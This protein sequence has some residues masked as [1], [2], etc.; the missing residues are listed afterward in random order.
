LPNTSAT[1]APAPVA[2][3]C[4]S[5]DIGAM[6]P[7]PP[8]RLV[9][10]G[11]VG[12]DGVPM[13][14]RFSVR[15]APEASAVEA[16]LEAA[17]DFAAHEVSLHV[18][19]AVDGGAGEAGAV[20]I[21]AVGGSPATAA[22]TTDLVTLGALRCAH[23]AF[24]LDLR[25]SG[26]DVPVHFV[27]YGAWSREG[28]YVLSV[29]GD[30]FHAAA[31]DAFADEAAKTLLLKDPAPPAP[32]DVAQIGARLGQVGLGIVVTAAVAVAVLGARTRRLRG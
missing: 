29:E 22:P 31:V 24:T 4:A 2:A 28:L 18:S 20:D 30:A 3:A 1:S 7:P 15:Y 27:S 14:A 19:A 13:P 10:A 17:R 25:E 5:I 12:L 16:T 6:T 11:A 23:A 8:A 21:V 9:A 26:H 32:S